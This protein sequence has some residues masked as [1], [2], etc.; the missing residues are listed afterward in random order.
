VSFRT[1]AE[2]EAALKKNFLFQ[3]KNVEVSRTYPKVT[4]I[5]RVSVNN[6]PYE[7]EKALKENMSRIFAELWRDTKDGCSFYC[8]WQRIHL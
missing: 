6:L 2:R 5:V 4:T 3:G 1:A 7:D 8:L